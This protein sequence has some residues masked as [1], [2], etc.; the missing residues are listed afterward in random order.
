MPLRAVKDRRLRPSQTRAGFRAIGRVLKPRGLN[1][2]LKIFPLTSFPE[3]FD[4]GETIL[5]DETTY[6][7]ESSQWEAD[8]VF[9]RLAGIR[10]RDQA[11][12]LRDTLVEVPETDRANLDQNEYYLDEIEG[13]AVVD[14]D[15]AAI[16]LVREVLQPGAND[17]YVVSRENHADLLVPAIPDVVLEVR[18]AD[19]TIVVDIPPGLDPETR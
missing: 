19:Q 16:G 3:R 6:R 17:V 11:E 2:E 12:A 5:I 13:C 8:V 14:S 4:P 10:H 9:V 15:G 1:G 7:V 18:I